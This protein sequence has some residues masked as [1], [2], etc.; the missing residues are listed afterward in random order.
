MRRDIQPAKRAIPPRIYR[1]RYGGFRR[2]GPK[3]TFIPSTYDH[4]VKVPYSG[5]FGLSETLTRATST[6]QISW[7]RI[8][9]A[10]PGEITPEVRE[11]LVRWP[12]ALHFS[13]EVTGVD[14]NR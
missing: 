5:L 9:V 8:D 13:T 3:G 1:L 14:F 4:Y 11:Q 7:F 6:G 12:D 10:K 2:R